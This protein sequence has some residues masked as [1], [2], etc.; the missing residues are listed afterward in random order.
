MMRCRGSLA[1]V[2]VYTVRRRKA[3][4][5]GRQKIEKSDLIESSAGHMCFL[6]FLQQKRI[7]Q[8]SA[9]EIV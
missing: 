1:C 4:R 8:R 3:I 6:G 2:V 5:R 7:R 9:I